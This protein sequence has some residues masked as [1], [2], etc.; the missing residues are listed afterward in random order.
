MLDQIDDGSSHYNMPGALRLTGDLNVQALTGA[1]GTIIERHESLR[2]YFVEGDNGQPLQVIRPFSGIE[3]P[4]TDI[5]LLPK[6]ERESELAQLV[7]AEAGRPFDLSADLMLRAQLVKVSDDEHVL[8]VN[9]HHIASDGWSMGILIN[10][11]STLYGAYVRGEENPLLPLE[12][13]YADYAQWQRDWLQGEVLDEQVG[14][15]QKQLAGL[16]VV[17]NLPLDNPRP[18]VQTFNGV[19]HYSVIDLR[20]SDKLNDLCQA[21]DGTLFM[22]LHAAFSVLLS[23][24]SNE[25]DIVV[26]SPIANREQAEVANLIGFF[27]NTLVLRSDLSGNPSFAGL[28]KRSKQMLLDAYAHQQVPFE[29]LVETL[30][31]ERS[32]SHSA[33]FQVMLVLQNNNAGALEL[34]GLTLSPVDQS[35]DI[36]KYDLTLS[37]TESQSGLELEWEYNTDLFNAGTI[38][39]LARHFERLL[40]GLVNAPQESVFAIDMLPA[41]EVHQQVIEW[42]DTAADYPKDKCVHELFEQHALETPDAVAVEFEENRL[43]YGELNA[44]AN[45]LARYLI[46]ERGVT[47]DTLVGICVERSLEMI[48][49]ILGILKAGGAYVPLDPSYP[50]AR[51][52]YMLDDANLTTVLTQQKLKGETPVR[53]SQA[54]ILDSEQM[55]AILS[56]YPAK[57]VP[58]DTLR[59]NHLAYVMYTSGSTGNP[60]GVMVEHTSV[61]N[62][63]SALQALYDFSAEDR[64][65]Q[66]V[67]LS[68]D[69]SVENIFSALLSGAALVIRT[70]AWV[71]DPQGWLDLCASHR[72]T[73]ADLPTQ[74]WQ[75]LAYSDKV[76]PAQLRQMIIGGQAV[77]SAALQA[78]WSKK[79]HLPKLYNAYGPTETTVNSTILYCQP[80]SAPQSIGRPV[81]N[82]KLYVLDSY[83]HLVPEGVAGELYIG[84]AGVTRGYLNLPDL[85]EA[86]FLKDAFSEAADAR[87]YKTG[88]L[89]RWLPD[90]NIEFL[91]RIDHQVKIRGFR[92]ELGEIEYQL[93]SHDEV[94]DAVVVALPNED[95]DKRLVAYVTHDNAGEM[96]AGDDKAQALRHGF[97]ESL[98]VTL[99]RDLQDYMVPSVFVVLEQLPLTPN[100]KVDRKGLPAPDM[101]LQ[102][103]A[104]VAP[105]TETEKQLC[106]I[107]QEVLG[108]EQV[109]ITDNF[110]ELGGHSLLA[111][112]LVATVNTRLGVEAQLKLLFSAPTV[113]EFSSELAALVPAPER[114]AIYPVSREQALFS[115]F[116]QQRLWLLDKIDGGSAHYNMPGALRL[117]GDLNIEA[118]T[119]G[120]NTIVERHESLRTYFIEGNDGQPLQIIR[121]FESIAVPVTDLSL[122]PAAERESG[123]ADLISAEAGKPFDLEADLMLRV[124]L[125]KVSYHEHV[126]LVTMHHI[127]SDGWSMGVLINEFS[128]LYG[129][130]MR[131]EENPLP[132]LEI[133]YADYAQWQRNWLQGEVLDKQLG[134]WQ[135]QLAGLPVVH[136][137]PLDKARPKVQ[138]FKGTSH[139]SAINSKV[140]EKLN[141]LCRKIGGTLFMGLHA[142]FSVLLS[143]YS[144]ETDIVI[145]SP[146]ANREQAEV[147]KL[148]GFFVNTLVLRS[149]LSG[150]PSFAALLEQSK[151]MLLDAYAHQQVPFEQ[152]VETLQPERSLSH[153]ALFQVMLVLHNNEEGTL[154]L[155]GL[156]LSPVEQLPELAKY[157]LSLNVTENASGLH[158]EWKYNTN[159]FDADTIARLAKHFELLLTGLVNAPKENVFAIEMLPAEEVH[160]Q[161]VQ[162]NAAQA[163]YPTDKCIHTLFEEQAQ[164]CPDAVAVV[165]EENRLTYGELNAK[166]NRLAHYLI[167]ERGVAPDTLVGICVERSL[168]MIVGILA[169]LKAGGAYVPLDPSYPAA[170]L[171]YIQED[172]NL[173]TVLTQST[174]KG[175]AQVSEAQAL[176]LDNEEVLARLAGYPSHDVRAE[177]LSSSHLAYVLYTSGSTGNPKGVMMPAGALVNLLFAMR[178]HSESLK[179]PLDILFHSSIGFDMSFTEM[180]L[181]LTS[182][183][184]LHV[185]DKE[186]QL[187]TPALV[188][189][190][191]GSRVSVLNLPYAL[192]PVLAHYC[193]ANEL[194]LPDVKVIISTA[195]QLKLTPEIQA[196]FSRNRHIELINHYGPSETHVITAINLPFKAILAGNDKVIGKALNNVM[197]YVLDGSLQPT[198]LGVAGELC[199]AGV[200][201]ARGYLNQSELTG[202]KFIPNPF[203]DKNNA[204]S[205]ERLYKTGDL[206]RWLP[207][208]N[209]EFLGRIDHQVKIRGFRVE[210]GEIEQQLLRHDAVND[211]VVVARESDAGDKRLVA[212]VTHDKAAV[213]LTDNEE[214]RLLRHGFIDS[215]KAGLA[216]ALPD[217]MV[218]SAFVVLEQLPLTPNGKVN[219]K[220]LP[221]P[222]MSEQQKSY[223]APETETEKWLCE[224]WQEVLGVERVGTRDNFFELGGHSLL[225][226]K[227]INRIRSYIDKIVHVIVLFDKST[228]AELA[229]YLQKNYTQALINKGLLD[230]SALIDI[231]GIKGGLKDSHFSRV[232]QLVLSY[233]KLQLDS[234]K[235][236]GK[237]VFILC[238][239]RSGSTLLRVMLAGHPDLFAP[240]EL[241]LLLFDSLKDRKTAFNGRFDLYLEGTLRAIMEIKGC[242]LTQAQKI[243]KEFEAKNYTV[244]QFY[245]AL[246]GWLGGLT[247]VDKT[248]TYSYHPAALQQAEAM[249]EEAHYIHLVRHPYGMISSFEQAKLDDIVYLDKNEFNSRELGELLWTESHSNILQFLENIPQNR[250]HR[251]VFEELV[252]DPGSQMEALCDFLSIDNNKALINPY[253]ATTKRMS[254]GIHK[255]SIMLGDI[256]FHGHQ[257]IDRQVGDAWKQKIHQDF[258]NPRSWALAQKLGYAKTTFK[259]VA[260]PAV[261]KAARGDNDLMLSFSQQ[262]LW[263][264]D[265]IDGGSAHY[266]MPE[267]IRLKGDLNTEALTRAL[268]TI[269]ERHESL[270]THF[271][272]G[273]DGQPLQLI[274]PFADIEVPMT[275]LSLLPAAER[276]PGLAALVSAEAGKPF[277]LSAD[278]MLRVRLVKVSID[279]HVLL[280]TM[281]HITSDGWS[282]GILINEFCALYGAYVR[283]EENPLPPLEIQYADYAQWQR[284]WLQGEVLDGQIG[285]WQEQ[286]AGLPVVHNLPLDRARPKVQSFNGAAHYS[287]IDSKVNYK[288][289][290]LCQDIGGTLFMGLHAAFSVLLARYSNETDIVVGS[291]IANREQ[292][293]VANLIGFFVNTL[294]L[295]SDLSDNPSFAAL[296]KQGKQML[297][298]AYAHQQVPFEQ[299]VETLQP[300]RSLSHS[301]L[302]QVMLVLQNNEQGRLELPDLTLSP[303]EQPADIAKYDLTL[304]VTES[305]TGLHLEWEYNT[306]LFNADTIERMARHFGLLLTGLVNAPQESVFAVEMLPAE[307]THRQLVQWNDTQ[308]DFPKDKCIHTLFEEQARLNP[309][310][311]A[312]VFEDNRLTYGELNEKAN[313]LA[314]YLIRERDVTPDTL[315]GICVERSLEMVVGILAILKAGGAY[316]PLDPG[317]PAT[318]LAYM[319]ED[320]NLT[321]VLMQ[322]GF[323]GETPISEARALYID[324]Q[325]M[326]GR[327]AAYPT[328]NVRVEALSPGHLAYVVYTSGSTGNPKGVMVEH[329]SVVSLV[330]STNYISF[331]KSDVVAQASNMSFDAM[332]FELWGALLNGAKLVH[333]AKEALIEPSQF[334]LMVEKFEIN[335][336]F[337]TT[338]FVNL[339]SAESPGAFAHLKCLFFGGENC[340]KQ[341]IQQILQYG[342]PTRLVHVYGPTE[343]T[344]FSL[345]KDLSDEYVNT[346]ENIALGT[347]TSNTTSYVYT[348]ADKIAPIG[349]AGELLL[350]GSGLARGYLNNPDLT[351]EKFIPNPFF[352]KN[353][354]NSSERLYKTGD[355]V[356]CLPDGDVEFLG[357]IDHQ[358]KVRGFRIELGEIEHKLLS[359]DA[360][361]DAVVVALASDEGD[362]RLVAYVTHDNAAVML[363]ENKAE[364]QA[365]RH[366]FID[367]LKAGLG[368]DLPGY[369]LPSAFVVL[370][371]LP[372]NPNG[373]VDR[374]KLP[375]P[376]MSLQQKA[377]VA[378]A[379][380]T[381]KLL[382]EI[383][384]D[385]LGVE[386]V[387]ITDNFFELGGHSL[388][389]VKLI[390]RVNKS[391][392]VVVELTKLFELT[393][394]SKLSVYVEDLLVRQ[395]NEQLKSAKKD[396]VEIE[397]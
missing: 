51:L 28:L 383:W 302:F 244:Q 305:K 130:Y 142:A 235:K 8:L 245:A 197:L 164:R 122:L 125:V 101:S 382:C 292:A 15:W 5:S 236:N 266:N 259:H 240:P 95:G 156:S 351:A 356:R 200:A 350:G 397:W 314:H 189:Y 205:S 194:T 173:T 357:R 252:K 187:N 83:Q 353:D 22:G 18:K 85:T 50:A 100:G 14:Y 31:P 352:D 41:E 16:P 210:L 4:V 342:A 364:A 60:K 74:F 45:Q 333:L 389:A 53:D 283:G 36:A 285:Y 109:G 139:Y 185:I 134:Y 346:A 231:G 276:E 169:I 301:A 111:T 154:E 366:E 13:Q 294:V 234:S 92:I 225:A 33:L 82:T 387:G 42:N 262:R 113:A 268:T 212:Y 49:G 66:F 246:Q 369:M 126:L 256:K 160:Q 167:R 179:A 373:K 203:F 71:T 131:G 7:S 76:I 335:I 278:L 280:V 395:K 370:E 250:Q 96:L 114:P 87:M 128:T 311:V 213:M 192:I 44:K 273:G 146:I 166:A 159:L 37:I 224:I 299:L 64:I 207:D 310:D 117:T 348:P 40:T 254:D 86:R 258:L 265:Q 218:P 104:Y 105:G 249:F 257:K 362:K 120:V 70:D 270:R 318:R 68:F 391:M 148:I 182:G 79:G 143:R 103:S 3:V 38:E 184:V 279:E 175:E 174:L 102:Q 321:T 379:T 59:P 328:D 29:Q 359:H 20:V 88:D 326:L 267:A 147:A 263:L 325:E 396:K 358:V 144:N 176:C 371:Q 157:D 304:N 376:D 119:R 163:D 253:D 81:A 63:I 56:G 217:Y 296:L 330:K 226:L 219:R 323:K 26:G 290:S 386:Q 99:S 178:E 6:A 135:E 190:I 155:P 361:N 24:Y 206:V 58:A 260:Q 110:F 129:A 247:L 306:D 209:I 300:E 281:H 381:E 48:V 367:A 180:F 191:I 91:G 177:G 30:Q 10:E 286:L 338:A 84:G 291:P 374:K 27:V 340:S 320:A 136:N 298:D 315:V 112:K 195:E 141:G 220:G 204:N 72:I 319:L 202:E 344:T 145:G 11:F 243:M 35:A 334:T 94:N 222:D 172:A 1:L 232:Q 25:T 388:L 12:I 375:L 132:P 89:V 65:L 170:R 39:R 208:G 349:V 115:S 293:E 274:R 181:C 21:V 288:L 368:R 355:L 228:V 354:P 324:E 233:P 384:Q 261:T 336:L 152:L 394:I 392:D 214:G 116:A 140:S 347:M 198:P 183:G 93:S 365:L 377:Y 282:M 229:G 237:A 55:I 372:L 272:D 52:A 251:V 216:Q 133:Q 360:V 201:L 341:A 123:L 121:P 284:G 287:I 61:V 77:A 317:Y 57:N 150:K 46:E 241:E 269:V 363:A 19:S 188:D 303:V 23:R 309:D 329:A 54:I 47:P 151:Q 327:L 90:G 17:H 149:D 215:L 168:E 331:D 345:W 138:S 127:A 308:A 390:T 34:P 248:P 223:V 97:I 227:V 277:N 337:V 339:I 137:L 199:V 230:A 9:M 242:D 161:L 264:L 73:I 271:V 221:A 295:R 69:V 162:W 62:Q 238:P 343:N 385:V 78:W 108:L 275:D 393:D 80:G 32:L 186:M 2:T 106:E 378:P 196:F 118:L 107:W 67:A 98:K 171:A 158:L 297:L 193:H 307:E 75:Q 211:A 153:S 322:S 239:H 380:A 124:R 289:N 43:T 316:V 165:F 332:T 313:Q 312:L 255:E